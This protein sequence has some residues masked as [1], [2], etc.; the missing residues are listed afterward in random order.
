MQ[1]TRHAIC[2]RCISDKH[3]QDIVKAE[4][5]IRNC[6]ECNRDTSPAFTAEELGRTLEPVLRQ[7][8][9]WAEDTGWSDSG[10]TLEYFVNEFLAQDVEFVESIVEA[11]IDA[12]NV[13]PPD[14]EEPF[15]DETYNYVR[16]NIYPDELTRQWNAVQK[17]LQHSRRYFSS[18][19]KSFFSHLFENIDHLQARID[20]ELGN[21]V[22]ETP[23]GTT[24]YRARECLSPSTL[25]EVFMDP[26]ANAGPPPPE[27]SHAGRMNAEGVTVLYAAL[28]VD[29]A[30]SEL[31]PPLGADTIVIRL[32]TTT[33]LR[34]LDFRRLE[35]A[36]LPPKRLST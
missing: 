22:C 33:D 25:Q 16:R 5:T 1:C 8:L 12:E 36:F 28:E 26:L 10:D 13:W 20:F 30:I 31:R 6:T 29:T 4:G 19:S 35:N 11:V 9:E 3:L 7:R 23:S 27:K 18:T 24:V 21:V 14:G 34:L 17:E 2:I 32:S 15:F